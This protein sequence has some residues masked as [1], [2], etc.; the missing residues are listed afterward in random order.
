MPPSKMVKFSWKDTTLLNAHSP[1]VPSQQ[2]S[3][4][5]P[6]APSPMVM[7]RQPQTSLASP[8]LPSARASPPVLQGAPADSSDASVPSSRSGIHPLVVS[9]LEKFGMTV[10]N[11]SEPIIREGLDRHQAM[12]ASRSLSNVSFIEE[13]VRPNSITELPATAELQTKA[14]LHNLA[15]F[16]RMVQLSDDLGLSLRRKR[17]SPVDCPE[18]GV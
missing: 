11:T 18:A 8:E 13:V 2:Q 1:A 9:A 14:P 15:E 3:G 12:K 17:T 10:R 6:M 7:Q 5:T 4:A 16:R